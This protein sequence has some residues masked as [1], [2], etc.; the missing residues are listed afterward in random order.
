MSKRV[1]AVSLKMTP[2]DAALLKKA[3]ARLWPE[4]P[5][6]RSSYVLAL[7]KLGAQA[8]LKK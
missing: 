1:I 2:E 8:V 7:A 5:I 3:A 4:A 6:T